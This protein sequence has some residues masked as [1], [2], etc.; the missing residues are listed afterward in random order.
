MIEMLHTLC[1]ENDR[2]PGLL[3]HHQVDTPISI[4]PLPSWFFLSDFF[5]PSDFFC[6]YLLMLL[7]PSHALRPF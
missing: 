7:P 6:H 1:L 4:E 5:T 2:L 3:L